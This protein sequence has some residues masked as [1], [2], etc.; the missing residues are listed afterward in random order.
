MKK[1]H[2]LLNT[3]IQKNDSV[4]MKYN[5]GFGDDKKD[6]EEN[7]KPDDYVRI[8]QNLQR[9]YTKF[10]ADRA[11]RTARR[12]VYLEVPLHV[13]F[14]RINFFGQ[15]AVHDYFG[16]WYQEFGLEAVEV[17]N[18]GTSVLFAVTDNNIDKFNAFLTAVDS[19]IRNGQ[20]HQGRKYP[21]LIHYIQDFELLTSEDIIKTDVTA[22]VF[23]LKIADLMV[24]NRELETLI[25]SLEDY[26]NTQGIAYIKNK[27]IG[28]IEIYNT[29]AFNLEDIIDNFDIF[30]QVTSGR[31]T[32]IRPN[33]FNAPDRDYGFEIA[34]VDNLPLVGVIDSG[35]DDRTPLAP[36][37]V[38]DEDLNLTTTSVREDNVDRGRGHG[39]AVAA[40]VALGG[41]AVSREYRGILAPHC[42]LLPIK[43]ID[44][45][46]AAIS[47]SRTLELLTIAK[48]KYPQIKIFTLTIN[49]HQ[50]KKFNEHYSS[51]AYALDKF[52]FEN[53]CL[54]FISTGNNS[55]A[56]FRTNE[57][58]DTAYFAEE[59]A[60]LCSPAE[61]LNNV[62]VGA[63][64][65]SL[66]VGGHI[67]IANG[68]E[69]PTIY[70]RT[71][72]YQHE[73]LKGRAKVNK[74]LFKPDLV[75]AGGDY[76][77]ERGWLTDIGEGSMLLLSADPTESFYR[78]F[79]TSFATPLAANVAV[80]IQK[81]YPNVSASSI[82]ALM[83]NHCSDKTIDDL[84]RDKQMLVG[85]G[86]L[87]TERAIYS[88]SD[89]INFIVEDT[90]DN[91]DL[92]V[93]P[94]NFP[95]YLVTD[96]LKKR[97]RILG[98]TA[99]ISYQFLP[100]RESQLGYCPVLI[101]FGFF[102]NH[103]G[104][105]IVIKEKDN[106]SKLKSGPLWSQ[107][108]R[109]KQKPNPFSN[110]QKLSFVVNV[111]E[112]LDERG[113]FKI[114]VHCFTHPQLRPGEDTAYQKDNRFS[115]AIAIE[116]TLKKPTGKLYDE[117]LAINE[118]ENILSADQDLEAEA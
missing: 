107:N 87:H 97:N 73:L 50:S 67:G 77:Y 48:Q 18:F 104:A 26:L 47:I 68:P 81:H 38:L 42:R 9:S 19:V 62:T 40:L 105:G 21:K 53:D 39:T 70:S 92:K 12:S 86:C 94:L 14:I 24:H 57:A 17:T 75:M 52:S 113:I 22:D 20:D 51:Y 16:R 116:E 100:I 23:I 27:E 56:I 89:M 6:K 59:E 45:D 66:G 8:G 118:I 85:H 64:S 83:L 114:G 101:A 28:I 7:E 117:M 106:K 110:T 63:C 2:V 36:L 10:N 76:C 43:I 98:V 90:I 82:K 31:A 1:P 84:I 91:G 61:S 99:T 108:S 5:Y 34:A 35:V 60:N 44:S 33:A 11:Q 111:D 41:E 103:E 46:N 78:L 49:F 95:K 72:H 79:G 74:T 13:D 37:I 115:I 112:L 58:Y 109:F 4:K 102:K 54:I 69:Y 15:F 3:R 30:L 88:D 71:G 25:Q 93:I 96:D 55:D 80:Q 65:D 29:E 32:I